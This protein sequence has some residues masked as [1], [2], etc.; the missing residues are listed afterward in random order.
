MTPTLDPARTPPRAYAVWLGL[1]LALTAVAV[2]A[3]LGFAG[4]L[5]AVGVVAGLAASLLALSHLE[6]GLW[7]TIAIITLLPFGGVPFKIVF[8]P[9]FLDLAM[10]VVLLVYGLEWMTGRRRRL[11]LTPAHGV[12]AVFLALMLFSFTAGL[13]NGPLTANLLRQF[14]EML[15]SI[16][17]VVILVDYV[18]EQA[19]LDRLVRVLLVG[20]TLAAV[21]GIG[22]YLL[23]DP[24]A[25]SALSALRV[26]N[27]PAGGVLRYIEDNPANAERAIATSV[28]PNALGGMLAMLG[29]LAAPQLLTRRSVFGRRWLAAGVFGL[30]LTCLLLTFSRGALTAL[31]AGLLFIALLRYRRMVVVLALGAALILVL[32]VTQDY[33]THFLS[34]LLGQDLATQMR[35]GEYKDALTLIG[36]YPWLGV[37]FAGTPEKD[38]YL[39]VSNAYL[40]IASKMGLVGLAGFAAVIAAVMGWALARRRRVYQDEAL[41]AVWLGLL[42][43][44]VAALTVGLVDHYFFNLAFQAA[45]ALFWIFIGLSLAATRLSAKL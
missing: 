23:P 41:T 22:L 32:P 20:G 35:F 26:F 29:A 12:I 33:V 31:A 4:P 9:T 8:T 17:F 43:G 13:P 10:A 27:Y 30:L 40:L 18:S 19:T 15:L 14:G 24:A 44:L 3:L 25:E 37:G 7:A 1:A 11:T 36:R 28:D 38:I 45:G 39:G 5:I 2:G 6:V 34:G 21:L 16:G 42:A